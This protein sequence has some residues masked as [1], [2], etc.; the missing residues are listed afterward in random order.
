MCCLTTARTLHDR[1]Q[2]VVGERSALEQQILLANGYLHA[3]FEDQH[4]MVD[5]STALDNYHTF[6]VR[7]ALDLYVMEN[8]L[9]QQ[10][11]QDRFRDAGW[12]KRRYALKTKR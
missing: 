6:V 5:R 2:P 8:V 11:A 12:C 10:A 4:K 9:T 1:L 3:P 7:F